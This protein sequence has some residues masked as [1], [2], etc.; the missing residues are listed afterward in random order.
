VVRK[1]TPGWSEDLEEMVDV[2]GLVGLSVLVAIVE[3]GVLFGCCY[4]CVI[5]KPSHQYKVTIGIWGMLID[6]YLY[7][8]WY[9]MVCNLILECQ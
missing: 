3:V 6:A 5:L 2:L 1:G 4:I 7:L 8:E 9:S